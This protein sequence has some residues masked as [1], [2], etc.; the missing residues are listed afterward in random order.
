[1]S[2]KFYIT[3][4]DDDKTKVR[5]ILETGHFTNAGE[6]IREGIALSHKRIEGMRSINQQL[7]TGLVSLTERLERFQQ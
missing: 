4:S 7:R 1:M 2:D 3:L 5:E 6:I